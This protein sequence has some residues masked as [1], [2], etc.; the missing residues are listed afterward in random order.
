MASINAYIE[1]A[2]DNFKNF[3]DVAATAMQG[4]EDAFVK[5]ALRGK[6][7]FHDMAKSILADLT[8]IIMQKAIAGLAGAAMGSFSFGGSSSASASAPASATG[9]LVASNYFHSGGKVGSPGPTR[10][11]PSSLFTHAPRFHDGLKYDEYPA[12]LQRGEEVTSASDVQKNRG[13]K[14]GNG[15]NSGDVIIYQTITVDASGGDQD[16]EAR[17]SKATKEGAEKGFN[18][19]LKDLRTR[20]P[21]YQGAK[22]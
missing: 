17:L 21:I 9:S 4:A 3:G 22:A 1:S 20:G 10:N 16:L 14:G 19:V 2:S 12:V 11:L 8:K 7:S 15:G 6:L 13:S 5:F 18:L